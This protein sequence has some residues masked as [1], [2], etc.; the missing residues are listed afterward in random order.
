[1]KLNA[2]LRLAM[3]HACGLILYA[4]PL[5]VI[6]VSLDGRTSPPAVEISPPDPS[7]LSS[8]RQARGHV[9]TEA[10][11]GGREI[12]AQA[13]E[14]PAGDPPEEQMQTLP[15]RWRIRLTPEQS[16]H[17]VEVKGEWIWPRRENA[18]RGAAPSPG[19]VEVLPGTPWLL[20]RDENGEVWEGSVRIRFPAEIWDQEGELS[21]RLSLEA[22]HR[23]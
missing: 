8:H 11:A 15:L 2:L 5:D 1:M 13:P 23:E 20:S 12:R 4:Q 18:G 6:L 9:R 10:Q 17:F 16:I 19:H 14:I 21:G 3:M 22:H 7:A